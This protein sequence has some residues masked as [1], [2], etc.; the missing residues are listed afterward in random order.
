MAQ[1]VVEMSGDE[2][3]LFRSYQKIIDQATKLDGKHK[4]IKASG[5][6]AGQQMEQTFGGKAASSLQNYITGMAT[7][8]AATGA[9]QAAMAAANAE[10]QAAL[11]SVERLVATRS[12]LQQVA[13]GGADAQRLNTLSNQLATTYGIDRAAAQEVVFSAKSEGFVGSES[14]VARLMAANELNSGSIRTLAGQIPGIFNQQITPI[15]GIAGGALAAKYSRLSVDELA[16]NLPKAAQGGAIAGSSP[17][18]TMA[19]AGIL[20]TR[21]DRA[22]EYMSTF[23]SQLATGDQRKKF[24]GLG[25]VGMVQKLGGMSESQRQGIL[26]TGKETNLSYMWI[27]QDMAKILQQRA[28]VQG[29][30]DNAGSFVTDVEAKAFDPTTEVGRMQA[31]RVESIRARNVAE[32]GAESRLAGGG[33]ARQTAMTR[34]KQNL[35]ERGV[36]PI[37]RW[38]ASTAMD[39]ADSMR[40]TPEMTTLAGR[41]GSGDFNVLRG[42]DALI[43]AARDLKD[44][45]ASLIRSSDSNRQRAAAAVQPE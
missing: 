1:V 16:A 38:G 32:I 30:M 4:G 25:I 3:K 11:A 33:Y 19:L 35:G 2:A 20:A 5:Q 26:G 6:A 36:N 37:S 13:E 27:Q 44:A 42:P 12:Q 21:G 7:L 45:A 28:E 17:A 29:A 39:F 22:S 23:A 40:M 24:A 41:L 34:F 9:F 15:Q 10:T 14:L 31:G 8:G 43:D 18:E